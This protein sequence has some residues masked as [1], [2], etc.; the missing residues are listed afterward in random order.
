MSYY[1]IN[2]LLA[3]PSGQCTCPSDDCQPCIILNHRNRVLRSLSRWTSPQTR[4]DD[5][6]GRAVTHNPNPAEC[7]TVAEGRDVPNDADRW[8]MDL[9]NGAPRSRLTIFG[10]GGNQ[11]KTVGGRTPEALA[12]LVVE[13]CRISKVTKISL[14]A[15]YGGGNFDAPEGSPGHVDVASSFA[16]NFHAALV[17]VSEGRQLF[18]DV[19]ARTHATT[20]DINSVRKVDIPHIGFVPKGLVSKFVFTWVESGYGKEQT[21]HMV[22]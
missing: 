18:S 5:R 16:K 13:G 4:S 20:T 9:V 12:K 6:T 1:D 15:C 11:S 2:V 19:S 7:V 8:I 3:L 17:L 22:N 10:H 21:W 14:L